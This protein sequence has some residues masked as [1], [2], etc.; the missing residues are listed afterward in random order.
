MR[1]GSLRRLATLSPGEWRL[2]LLAQWELLAARRALR[3]R[4]TGSLV[5]WWGAGEE[6]GVDG[7]PSTLPPEQAERARAVGAAV[8]RVAENGPVRSTC[9]ARAVAIQRLLA[10]EGL[11]TGRLLV[12]VRREASGLEAHAWVELGGLVLGDRPE[13]VGGFFRLGASTAVDR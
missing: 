13:R 11:P 6:P 1:L 9:L 4:P 12:G 5:Q 7:D 8:G 3:S 10:R 2:L